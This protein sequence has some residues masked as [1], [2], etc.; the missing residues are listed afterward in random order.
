MIPL[1]NQPKIIEKQGNQTVFVIEGLWPGYGVTIGNSLRRVLLSS[2]EGTAATQTKI[3]GVQQ[4]FSTLPGVLEDVVTIML[5]LKQLRFKLFG[6]EPQRAHLSV[7]GEKQVKAADFETP[8][9]LEVVNKSQH[10]AT[11]TE[12][13]A[14]LDIEI[15]VEKG[16]GYR[17]AEQMKKEKMEIGEIPLDAVFTPIKKVSYKVENMRV[18][19]RTDFDRLTLE[20]ETDGTINPE[21]AFHQAVETLLKHF[22]LFEETYRPIEAKKE[23]AEEEPAEKPK[24]PAKTKVEEMAISSRTI[25][26][27]L[28]NNF[29]TVEALA[30]KTE[31]ALLELEGMSEKGITEIKKALKKLDLELKE[32]KKA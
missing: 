14:K 6:E 7:K 10:L 11:L 28:K 31:S 29:K 1:P 18:G 26:I 4:E 15:Q 25:N 16:L 8:S 12:K 27:L 17:P 22:Q 3:A 24:E 23:K 19:E 32:E 9:Q 13:G 2:L 21:K 20:I 5:N 30:K